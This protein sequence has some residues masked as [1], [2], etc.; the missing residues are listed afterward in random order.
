M[1]TYNLKDI[2]SA[3]EFVEKLLGSPHRRKI[4]N[5][6]ALLVYSGSIDSELLLTLSKRGVDILSL[7]VS[8]DGKIIESI[9]IMDQIHKVSMNALKKLIRLYPLLA[10]EVQM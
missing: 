4:L 2:S 5:N 9:L 10:S 8:S 3:V 1:Y 6:T 7:K